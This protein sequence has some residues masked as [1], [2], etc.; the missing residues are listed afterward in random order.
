M[1]SS[2]GG[3]MMTRS[4]VRTLKSHERE[5]LGAVALTPTPLPEGE[6]LKQCARRFSSSPPP[7]GEG[8]KQCER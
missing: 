1:F 7:S 3:W 4:E 5:V 2:A 8:L 6:G